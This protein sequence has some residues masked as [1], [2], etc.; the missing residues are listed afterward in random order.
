[1]ELEGIS[2]S[3]ATQTLGPVIEPVLPVAQRL[4]ILHVW[5]NGESAG[6]LP[7]LVQ[8]LSSLKDIASRLG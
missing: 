1:M 6:D 7:N 8:K 3:A 5:S 2:R 4:A